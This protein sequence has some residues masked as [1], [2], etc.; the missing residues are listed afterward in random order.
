MEFLIKW[1]S[2]LLIGPIATLLLA[3]ITFIGFITI[4]RAAACIINEHERA[5]GKIKWKWLFFIDRKTEVYYDA[6]AEL[7][8]IE[9]ELN[10]KSRE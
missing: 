9:E 6:E 7:Y 8:N 5:Y 3:A 4:C 1:F 2:L 10:R